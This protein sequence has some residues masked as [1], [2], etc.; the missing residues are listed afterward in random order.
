VIRFI[1]KKRTSFMDWED[2]HRKIR[3]IEVFAWQQQVRRQNIR[4][5]K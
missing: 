5:L 2:Y 4:N 1:F 3:I